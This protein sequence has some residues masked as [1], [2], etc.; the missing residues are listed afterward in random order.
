ML[1]FSQI[2]PNVNTAFVWKGQSRFDS[3]DWHRL[4]D[5]LDIEDLRDIADYVQSE[6]EDDSGYREMVLFV[7]LID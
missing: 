6:D 2:S 7:K 3:L 4:E 5:M 1:V